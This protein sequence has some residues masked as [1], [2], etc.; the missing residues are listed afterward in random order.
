M[1]WACSRDLRNEKFIRYFGWKTRRGPLGKPRSKWED[2]I[3]MDLREKE[4]EGVD[5]MHM[6][7]GRDQWRAVGKTVMNLRFQ[8]RAENFLTS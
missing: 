1:G 5:W 3:R 8:K 6:T 4:W 2:N 7:Q